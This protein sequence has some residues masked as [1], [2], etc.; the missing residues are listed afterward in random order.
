MEMS[1]TAEVFIILKWKDPR[2]TFRDLKANGNFFSEEM[3]DLIWLPRII[4][5]NTAE[6]ANVL[7]KG[8]FWVEVLNEGTPKLMNRFEI[9]EGYLYSGN[10][11]RLV[12]RTAVQHNFHCDFRLKNYPFDTQTCDITLV[13]EQATLFY[14]TLIPNSLEYNG[15]NSFIPCLFSPQLFNHCIFVGSSA[16]VYHETTKILCRVQNVQSSEP[17]TKVL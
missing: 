3:L 9:H 4:F 5:A 2:I 17:C 8:S 7:K 15:K 14:A 11:N 13:S 1:F 6:N 12:L 10:E 16:A